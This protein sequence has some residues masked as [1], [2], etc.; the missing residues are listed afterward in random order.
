VLLPS[1]S[2]QGSSILTAVTPQK[3]IGTRN[4]ILTG[5]VSARL[6]SGF[7][8]NSN[9]PNEEYLIPLRLTWEAA[10]LQV[11]EVVYPKPRLENYSFSRKPVSVFTGDFDIVTRFKVPAMAPLGPGVLSGK[12]RYQACTDSMCFPPRIVQVRLPIR[13]QAK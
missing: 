12:L 4:G 10:P 2:G 3:T 9:K 7:H 8:V 13:I 5:K 1:L 11:V 6:R